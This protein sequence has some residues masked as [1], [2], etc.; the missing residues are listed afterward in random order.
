MTKK[1]LLK[2]IKKTMTPFEWYANGDLLSFLDEDSL[3]RILKNR[4]NKALR[5]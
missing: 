1:E 5:S 4:Q 3:K 2:E